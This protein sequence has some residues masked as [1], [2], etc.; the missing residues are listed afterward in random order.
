[1]NPVTTVTQCWS[2]G[3]SARSRCSTGSSCAARRPEPARAADAA[4]PAGERAGLDGASRRSA[5]GRASAADCDDVAA[6]LRLAAAKAARA[7]FPPN[8]ADRLRARARRKPARPHPLRATSL[9]EAR[10]AEPERGRHAPRG[11]RALARRRRS[12]T[13]SSRTSRRRDPPTRGSPARRARGPDR[14]RPRG[15]GRRRSSWPSWRRSS[16]GIRCASGCARQLMLALYRSGRQAD[17]LARTTTRAARSSTSS[18]SS[19][20]PSSRRSTA[21]SCARSGRSSASRRLRSRI[22]TTR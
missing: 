10:A 7:R 8:A 21:R 6:E 18:G 1:M 16:V 11:A 5:L 4:A 13:R 20:A 2:S 22:T 19:P 9:R 3:S 15:R 14:G 17:A 12:P